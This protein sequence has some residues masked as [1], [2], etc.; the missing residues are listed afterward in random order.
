MI[1]KFPLVFSLLLI[2]CAYN[3]KNVSD[4]QT[5]IEATIPVNIKSDWNAL[6]DGLQAAVGSINRRY[7]KHEIPDVQLS[8]EW[9]GTAWRGER[10]S[11][12]L[13]LWSKNNVDNIQCEI[14]DFRGTN[15][16]RLSKEIAKPHFI[17]YVVTD[18]YA[19]GCSERKP[20]NF[21]S[22][23]SA[24]VLD[25][26]GCFDMQ[27]RTSRPIWITVDIPVDAQAGIYASSVKIC[28]SGKEMQTF[29]IKMEVQ[30]RT[31]PPPSEWKFHLDL[32]Q[33]PYAVARMEGVKPWSQM[34]WD[35]L[36]PTMQMLANAGQK[37]IT[38]TL[39]KR[40]WNGQT[41]DAFDS[42]I[43]WT[44]KQDGSWSYDYTV[45]DNW[46]RFMMNLGI[47]AQINC[48]SMLPWGDHLFYFDEKEKKEIKT[49]V[50]PGSKAYDSLWR[51]F[52][53]D[54][55]VHLRENGWLGITRIA[56]DERAPEEMQA[57]LE[58]LHE[59]AP[60]LSVALADNHH[61]YKLY[62]DQIWDLCVAQGTK[63]DNKDR[64]YRKKKSFITTWYVCCGQEFPNVFTFSDPAEATF[65]AWNTL[66]AGFDGFLR[67]AYNSWVKDPLVDSRFRNWPAGDTFIV[68]P[69]GRSSIRFERLR[70]GIQ[71]AEKIRILREEYQKKGSIQA[72]E[73]LDSLNKMVERFN[74]TEKTANIEQMLSQGK[75][76]LMNLSK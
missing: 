74:I 35:A 36:H 53:K 30:D 73:K 10:V 1:K 18:E 43:S 71:D 60:D 72:K 58:L 23:L 24:D 5:Y 25:N 19:D 21:T 32:W 27:S 51:P 50:V 76:L 8:K 6:P 44:K 52:L 22:S 31:L 33:N 40:P 14:S 29:T 64:E 13:V 11:L 34:H 63:I 70:E 39:N 28:G 15:G 65:I 41:E 49:E 17:R 3:N 67:W 12:Q 69:G 48:Y 62:P 20:E 4:C 54:F 9:L 37:V 59:T 66:A 61:G 42:M 46:V 75:E 16:L 38:A 7:E 2:G 47:K 68:Y 26:I 45:F 56:M 55:V 57:V